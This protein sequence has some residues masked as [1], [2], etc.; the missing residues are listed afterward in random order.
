MRYFRGWQEIPR[1]SLNGHPGGP[2]W[3]QTIGFPPVYSAFIHAESGA[4]GR[5]V[6]PQTVAQALNIGW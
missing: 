6:L 1:K 4:E 3:R 5:L 2:A